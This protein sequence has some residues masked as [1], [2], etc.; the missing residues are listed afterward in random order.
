MVALKLW[1]L[2]AG[3]TGV[4]G[5][6]A[7]IGAI[8]QESSDLRGCRFSGKSSPAQWGKGTVWAHRHT[9]SVHA[10][11]CGVCAKGTILA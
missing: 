4:L 3:G 1:V 11:A 5:K 7:W 6:G 8:P 9:G 10:E 2:D